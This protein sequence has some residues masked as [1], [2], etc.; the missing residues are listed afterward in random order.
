MK[1]RDATQSVKNKTPFPESSSAEE[2]EALFLLRK[3]RKISDRI[4]LS[5]PERHASCTLNLITSARVHLIE[6]NVTF[7]ADLF[8]VDREDGV[9]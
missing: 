3:K 9:L 5:L 7:D 6:S 8:R 1:A 4:S 2:K